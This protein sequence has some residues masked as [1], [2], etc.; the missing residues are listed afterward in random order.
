MQLAAAR[1]GRHGHQPARL[2]RGRRLARIAE[3]LADDH[4]RLRQRGVGIADAH[5]DGGDVVR[6]RTGEEP[7]RSRG[8]RGADGRTRGQRLVDDVDA[9]ERVQRDVGIVGD[10]ERD[11]LA[12]VADDVARDGRLQVAIRARGRGHT[13]GDDR[14]GGHVG[15]RENEPNTGQLAGALGV[16]AE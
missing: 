6:V 7:R 12:D 4:G 3:A 11:G 2:Q 8:H 1:I 9:L 5:R 16:D 15:S 13:V 10:D 14:G